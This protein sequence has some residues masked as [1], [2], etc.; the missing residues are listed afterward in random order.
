MLEAI[1]QNSRSESEADMSDEP[2]Q[3]K[4]EQPRKQAPK[5]GDPISLAG[6]EGAYLG[7]AHLEGTNLYEAQLEGARLSRAHLAGADLTGVFLDAATEVSTA[8]W[9]APKE[10]VGPQL[11][12]VR[13]G[14]VNLTAV[15]WEHIATLRDEQLAEQRREANQAEKPPKKRQTRID[16]YKAAGRA[17]RL[18][19]VA[20]RSQGLT[21][22]ATR[23]HYRAEIMDRNALWHAHQFG[24]WLFSWL[25]GTFA[26]YGDRLGRLF[27]TYGITVG[28]FALAMLGVA[29]QAGSHLSLDTARDTLVLSVTSFHGR[30][31]QPPG[32]HP[33]DAGRA[34]SDLRVVDRRPLYCGVHPS[35]HRRLILGLALR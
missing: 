31:V 32:L 24:R 3:G 7:G 13:W 28:L 27:A 23:Y 6:L 26:G 18:L 2:G 12:D 14:G 11:A 35:R 4:Q 5:W 19:F 17:Y 21:A 30:G 9:T 25:L 29:L 20:L 22:P 1:E 10:T 33:G 8:M 16:E 15:D 34:G